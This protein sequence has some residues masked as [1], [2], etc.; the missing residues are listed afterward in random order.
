MYP[1]QILLINGITDLLQNV[2]MLYTVILFMYRQKKN[3]ERNNGRREQ[4]T[5]TKKQ[6]KSG[7]QIC[8]NK[9]KPQK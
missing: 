6:N 5:P 4:E 8:A 9:R 3:E 1:M 2:D 7:L